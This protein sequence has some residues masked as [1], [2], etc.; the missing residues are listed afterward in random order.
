M[1]GGGLPPPAAP[2][3]ADASGAFDPAVTEPV[4][5]FAALGVTAFTTTRANGTFRLD[6]A[7]PAG[8]VVARW[9]A[10]QAGLGVGRLA[11]ARQVHGSDVL[12]HGGEW[13]GWLR[14]DGADGHA[15]AA[16]GTAL[17]VSVADCVPVFLARPGG[18]VALLHAGWRGIAAGILTTGL[19]ALSGL[20]APPAEIHVHLGPAICGRCYEVGPDVH[21]RLTGVRPGTA[22]P[23]DLR[24][25][26][27]AQAHAAGVRHV[28][29]SAWCTRC[30]AGRFYSHRA[31][32]AGRQVAVLVSAPP[33]VRGS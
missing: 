28:S 9:H 4:A 8:E 31:G 32:D 18:P 30:Q 27:A 16:A 24:A 33:S 13:R 6:G 20:G 26:L 5:E 2:P 3:R 7:D 22:A 12:A 19:R 15:T 1:T 23:A 11:S 17:A 14:A 25:L 21:E 10:L 29:R